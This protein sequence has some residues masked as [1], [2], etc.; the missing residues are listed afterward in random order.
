MHS[1]LSMLGLSCS[2]ECLWLWTWPI[3]PV[4]FLLLSVLIRSLMTSLLLSASLLSVRLVP[5]F[6]SVLVVRLLKTVS[7]VLLIP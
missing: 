7:L 3:S 2:A 1:V 4:R 6:V 5:R